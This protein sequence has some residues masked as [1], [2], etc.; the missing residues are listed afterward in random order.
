MCIKIKALVVRSLLV[1][2]VALGFGVGE[3]SAQ[4]DKHRDSSNHYIFDNFLRQLANSYGSSDRREFSRCVGTPEAKEVAYHTV[5]YAGLARINAASETSHHERLF[6]Q[7][8]EVAKKKQSECYE[9]LKLTQGL[10][11]FLFLDQVRSKN[12]EGGKEFGDHFIR[13]FAELTANFYAE[14]KIQ[15]FDNSKKKNDLRFTGGLQ[16]TTSIIYLNAELKPYNLGAV[17]FHELD[18]FF[19]DKFWVGKS[20]Y[21][22]S[23][24]Q[25]EILKRELF[26]NLQAAYFQARAAKHR[27]ANVPNFWTTLFSKGRRTVAGF[28]VPGDVTLFKRGG[29]L[30]KTIPLDDYR[31]SEERFE[32]E[33]RERLQSLANRL[34]VQT[35]GDDQ[36]IVL[37][38][39][40]LIQKGY[41]P[42]LK[43]T[44]S[45]PTASEVADFNLLSY[46][47]KDSYTDRLKLSEDLFKP[48]GFC[49]ALVDAQKKNLLGD[50]VGSKF[51]VTLLGAEGV[52]SGSEGVHSG[53]E[54]VHSGFEGIHPCV[55][56]KEKL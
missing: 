31:G 35:S 17:L 27:T 4:K 45:M 20:N 34:F 41:F 42:T 29:L 12:V 3:A 36:K 8:L 6:N 15:F 37:D 52:H 48:T 14:G 2:A 26:S 19:Q 11:A 53:S 49:Q 51:K 33:A 13:R 47:D 16:C 44:L 54:G 21:S 56:A 25:N 18:H 40:K 43:E 50:Y 46:L 24:I 7:Y 28:E 5:E 39:V 1:C 30:F 55:D 23:E 38:F 9:L 22:I 10:T 32:I